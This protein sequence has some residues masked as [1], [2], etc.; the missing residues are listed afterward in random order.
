VS[1]REEAP[2]VVER[3]RIKIHQLAALGNARRLAEHT[4]ALGAVELRELGGRPR[5]A[6][7]EVLA[8]RVRDGEVAGQARALRCM[9]TSPSRS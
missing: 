1:L 7:L 3:A 9:G 4:P 5:A 2:E 8:Q 6:R